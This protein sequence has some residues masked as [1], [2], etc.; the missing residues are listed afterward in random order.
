MA[1]GVRLLVHG[2]AGGRG[3]RPPDPE[4]D[5]ALAAALGDALEAGGRVLTAGGPA[6]DA[7][8]AA[9][10][11]LEEA[12]ELNAGRGSVLTADGRVQM[13]ACVM[14][15]ARGRAGAVA[16]VEDLLHPVEAALL[17]LRESP[18]VLLVGPDA[19]AFALAHGADPAP[20][21]HL[22]TARRRAQ[23]DAALR[24]GAP[25]LDHDAADDEEAG[26]VG[27]VALDAAG[28]LAAASSTGGMSGQLAGRVG[29]SPVPGAGVWADARVAVSATGEG[30]RFLEAAFAHEVAARVRLAAR[31]LAEACGDA[32]GAV[33]AAG[34]RGGCIALGAD[35]AV[36]MPFTTARM[37]RGALGPDGR[38][39]VWT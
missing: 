7:V 11:V 32:L 14:D 1:T 13:D 27:A 2:G 36:A 18:H 5:R 20:P 8:V 23:R 10:R 4:R 39:Q 34:G 31:P 29:D 12:P 35:G 3:A 6:V 30:E 15:G 16:G 33:S 22:V 26:T 38:A 17:V 28:R 21:G 19:R 25:A 24:R 9:V 37:L